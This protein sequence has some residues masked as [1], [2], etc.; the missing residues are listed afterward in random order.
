MAVG[1]ISR[2]LKLC[3]KATEACV[4]NEKYVM[5]WPLDEFQG[6]QTQLR[7]GETYSRSANR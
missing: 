3:V 5:R 2:T 1:Q 6:R 7:K 4:E